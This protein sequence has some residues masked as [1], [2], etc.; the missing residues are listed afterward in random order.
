[1]QST[2]LQI[3]S[4]FCS[5]PTRS[6]SG[7]TFLVTRTREGNIV[8]K[9]KLESFG[10]GVLELPSISILPPSSWKRLDGAISRLGQY[11]WIVFTSAN[12]VKFFFDRVKRKTPNLLSSLKR[13]KEIPRFACVGPSTKR[14]LE[15]TGFRSSLQP[16]EY[17]TT[18]LGLELAQ[19]LASTGNRVLLARAEVANRQ[20]SQILRDSG[21]EVDEVPVYKTTPR[22]KKLRPEFLNK[23]TDVTL[24]SPSTVEGLLRSVNPHD[25]LTHKILVHCIGPVTAK[26]AESR[27]LKVKNVAKTHTLDGLLEAIVNS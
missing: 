11:D 24:T 20:I 22:A 2:A 10:A 18:T 21:A 9:R 12:G 26:Q 17:M 23:I 7:R 6:L 3:P 14:E 15:A 16:N 1:M 4:E 5:S 13:R 25:I 8:E 19:K 27:G